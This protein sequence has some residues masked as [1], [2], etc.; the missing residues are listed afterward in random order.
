VP[1]TTKSKCRKKC[2][3]GWTPFHLCK[4]KMNFFS[5]LGRRRGISV[6]FC[7]LLCK[8]KI[9]NSK[10]QP[11][12]RKLIVFWMVIYKI[13]LR[14]FKLTQIQFKVKRPVF[15]LK[16]RSWLKPASRLGSPFKRVG[17]NLV[18]I[19]PELF[20]NRCYMWW[21]GVYISLNCN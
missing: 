5:F 4:S 8:I 20:Q 13:W 2:R 6:H 10:L 17:S 1:K 15:L 16:R 9:N 21:T 14:C 11:F 3:N 7:F 18:E 12:E 19:W